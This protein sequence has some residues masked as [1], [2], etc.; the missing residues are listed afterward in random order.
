MESRKFFTIRS[1]LHP[2]WRIYLLAMGLILLSGMV[3]HGF[4]SPATNQEKIIVKVGVYEN[5]P[6]IFTD[7]DGK[8]TGF[9]PD[10]LAAMAEKENWTLVY[11]HG[12]W[13]QCLERLKNQ[14]IDI[15]PD[16]AV[17]E[18]R[19]QTYLF[20]QNSVLESWSRVYVG[21]ENSAIH[22]ILDLKRKRVAV[23]RESINFKGPEGIKELTEQF[24][25][26]CTFLEYDSYE[27]AFEAVQSAA[28]DAV[29]TN[30]NFGNENREKFNLKRTAIVFQAGHIKFAFPKDSLTARKLAQ[31]I[32]GHMGNF[33]Q[34]N[35]SVY[36]QLLEKYFETQIVEKKVEVFP[37]WI[38][39]GVKF[40]GMVVFIL[41]LVILVSRIQVRRKTGELKTKAQALEASELHLR[42]LIETIPDQIWVKDPQGVYLSCNQH[43]EPIMG[44][45]A[46]EIIGKRD[47]DFYDPSAANLFQ[48]SDQAAMAAGKPIRYEEERIGPASGPREMFETIKAPMV[49]PGGRL[50]GVLGI[51]RDITQR[52]QTEES[53]VQSEAYHKQLF[54]SSPIALV[55]QDFSQVTDQI[56]ALKHQG[57]QDLRSYLEKNPDQLARLIKGVINVQVNQ[58]AMDLYK[59]A[60]GEELSNF[61]L[62]S[63]SGNQRHFV[64]QIVDFFQGKEQFDGQV[65]IENFQG[66]RLDILVRKVVMTRQAKGPLKILASLVDVT[67]LHQ[68]FREK[69]ELEQQ[70]RH[71]QKMETIG[72]LAGGIAH[73]FNNILVPILGYTELL[74][75]QAAPDSSLKEDLEKIHIASLRAKDLV[76]QILTFSRKEMGQV[77]P[78][79]IPPIVQEALGLIRATMPK[80]IDIQ[81][82][83]Q[84]IGGTVMGDLTQVHQI[85]MNLGTNAYHAMA[86]LGGTLK[87]GLE[88]QILEEPELIQAD[89]TPGPYACLTV[90]DNGVGMEPAVLERI[91]D[92]FFTTKEPGKGTGMGL[93]V[94]HGIVKAMKGGIQVH[95]EA[96]KGTEFKVYL[97]LQQGAE[98][99][100]S[101]ESPLFKGRGEHILTVDDEEAIL[102]MEKRVLENLGYEVTAHLS[103]RDALETFR[104][105]PDRFDLVITDM[106]MPG[107]S[108][109]QLVLEL[110]KIRPG[111]PLVICS[112]FNLKRSA[113]SDLTAG[114]AHFLSKPFTQKEL[115]EMVQ[116]V[117][118]V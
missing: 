80:T 16:V 98:H 49:D 55:I 76:K 24:N 23:L 11:V 2:P 47:I 8:V 63:V 56:E 31:R 102:K 90:T 70:L 106:A 5:S 109:D 3:T 9:W 69:R 36:Y 44:A 92:P 45:K 29:V 112:G 95:S 84:A 30:R 10:L 13:S 35:D 88:E 1:S 68:A 12:T 4:C 37:P 97:P 114:S 86:A 26:N 99:L 108:G 6:K 60:S 115:A 46:A 7:P 77:T 83:L 87:I 66:N 42:T 43:C 73:D 57:I 27:L 107:M 52:K 38:Q 61:H 14:T 39:T 105:S 81:Q 101:R 32:D 19:T 21:N 48:E 93:S 110:R 91:F 58:A 117:L 50:V 59:A 51:A 33:L 67:R 18:E 100:E 85:V 89:M 62:F 28:A 113:D 78:I 75:Q 82:D 116:K 40:T 79:K 53:L 103:S 111:L 41:L 74:L 54:E 20:S 104:A 65:M 72:V 96:G 64:D 22:S 94:V 71:V 118:S 25:L 15:M 34:D 17:T